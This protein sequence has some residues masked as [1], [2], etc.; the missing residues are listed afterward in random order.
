[1]TTETPPWLDVLRRYLAWSAALH[2]VWEIVQLPFYTLWQSGTWREVA[3]AVVHCTAG[4][5]MIATLAL[6]AALVSV[7]T[8]NW[9]SNTATRVCV[10]MLAIGIGYTIYSE[11]LNTVV[12]QSWTYT[13]A[14]PRLPVLGTGLSPLL[15]WVIV[16]LLALRIGSVTWRQSS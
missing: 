11:W 4:D 16:P 5:L 8:A 15:Q 14:M 7:G 3:F 13:A 12:R 1:M 9:P 6:V 10:V 2:F